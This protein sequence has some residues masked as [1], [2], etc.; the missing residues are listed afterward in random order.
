MANTTFMAKLRE[1]LKAARVAHAALQSAQGRIGDAD[2]EAW[3]AD[4]ITIAEEL[5]D[6]V[7]NLVDGLADAEGDVITW[8]I[9]E[10]RPGKKRLSEE[11][12]VAPDTASVFLQPSQ[13]EQ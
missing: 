11:E 5:E 1:A 8:G 3:L 10:G 12:V 7:T 6:G 4:C 9:I 2:A 13:D